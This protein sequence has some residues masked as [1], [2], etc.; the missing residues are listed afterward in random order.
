MPCIE[1]DQDSDG[2]R[3]DHVYQIHHGEVYQHGINPQ[4]ECLWDD[5]VLDFVRC[6]RDTGEEKRAWAQLQ[7]LDM[8]DNDLDGYIAKFETLIKKA[9]RDCNEVA[10]VDVFNKLRSE[11]INAIVSISLEILRQMIGFINDF[12]LL[13]WHAGSQLRQVT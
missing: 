6:F 1:S 2:V 5:F 9:G 10:H 8:Q 4:N 11:P 3:I 13:R 12:T 7:I